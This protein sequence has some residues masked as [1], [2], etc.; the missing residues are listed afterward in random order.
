MSLAFMLLALVVSSISSCITCVIGVVGAIGIS[1][2]FPP[3][4]GR[5]RAKRG[6]KTTLAEHILIHSAW[7]AAGREGKS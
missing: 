5:G 1:M 3:I 2:A 4:R 6:P 7:L